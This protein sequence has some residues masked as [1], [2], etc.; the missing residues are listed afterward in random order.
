MSGILYFRM[1]T[2]G[3]ITVII[4][5]P[6]LWRGERTFNIVRWY[7]GSIMRNQEEFFK[8]THSYCH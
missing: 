3:E 6:D 7:G 2:G 5:F 4:N 8:L 1:V